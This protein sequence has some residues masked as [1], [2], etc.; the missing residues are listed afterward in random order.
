MSKELHPDVIGAA[1]ETKP[2]TILI[3]CL[4]LVSIF[5]EIFPVILI[6]FF[7]E[8]AAGGYEVLNKMM[9]NGFWFILLTFA[10]ALGPSIVANIAKIIRGKSG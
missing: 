7:P 2:K 1:S 8:K 3:F 9:D 10:Y 6:T 4:F 5:C